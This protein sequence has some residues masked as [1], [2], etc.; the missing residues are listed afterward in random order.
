MS[1]DMS[2]MRAAAQ[3]G[4]LVAVLVG[5][6]FSGQ[7]PEAVQTAAK[8]A[9]R[10][11]AVPTEVTHPQVYASPDGETHFR[12][13]RVPLTSEVGG[14]AVEPFAQSELQAA[15]TIRHAAFPAG[16]GVYDRDHGVF[17]N[18]TG[19]RFVTVRR[20]VGWI[21]TSDGETR[22]FQAGDVI[23]VL[24]VAP[25]RGHILW[26]GEGPLVVLFSNYR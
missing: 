12:D 14:Q 4:V 22:R 20:G 8:K 13:V 1:G 18:P 3:V 5:A 9:V 24:D 10:N 19:G 26:V 2:R 16:W 15:T 23:E 17:H 7:Q 21:R 11:D 6:S 25:S